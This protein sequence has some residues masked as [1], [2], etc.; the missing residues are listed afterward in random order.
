MLARLL[1][2]PKVAPGP[3]QK[4]CVGGPFPAAAAVKLDG[5]FHRVSK[6]NETM[7]LPLSPPRNY[8]SVPFL[9]PPLLLSISPSIHPF[10]L[11]VPSSG[12]GC[13]CGQHSASSPSVT[14]AGCGYGR[15]KYDQSLTHFARVGQRMSESSK[16]HSPVRVDFHIL[17]MRPD[18]E[19][20]Y[21]QHILEKSIK[22]GNSAWR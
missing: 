15:G 11:A 13:R 6:S 20:R 8:F 22:I 16:R 5:S 4:A 1:H 10:C 3:V 17:R 18:S 2:S 12:C 7:G 14:A 21:K 9:Y 19:S